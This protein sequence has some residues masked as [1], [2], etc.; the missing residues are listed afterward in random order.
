M[1]VDLTGNYGGLGSWRIF[2]EEFDEAKAEFPKWK[3][4]N[5]KMYRDVIISM[6]E[7]FCRQQQQIQD[8]QNKYNEISDIRKKLD[9]EKRR[10]ESVYNSAIFRLYRK[11]RYMVKKQK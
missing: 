5:E 7:V 11:I 8:L 6:T 2:K 9:E 1:R 10:L 4:D 3:V